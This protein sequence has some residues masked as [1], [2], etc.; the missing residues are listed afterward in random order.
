MKWLD[1]IDEKMMD[2]PAI[3]KTLWEL[4]KFN[5]V[6]VVCTIVQLTLVNVLPAVFAG[7]DRPLPGFL[8]YIF[9]EDIV[10]KGHSNWAYILPYFIS[11]GT[12]NV[13]GYFMNMKTTFDSN[14]PKIYFVYYNII[15]I[16][17]IFFCTWIQG[18]AGNL[19]MNSTN[20]FIQKHARTLASFTGSTVMACILFPLQKF[21][22]FKDRRTK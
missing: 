15:L 19:F 16:L 9:S 5:L 3:V 6:G 7:F 17:L 4:V 12:A 21:V 20:A 8:A 2:K 13:I 22:F 10:G 14:A 18:V 1:K 11:L